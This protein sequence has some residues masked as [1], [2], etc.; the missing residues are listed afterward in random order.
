MISIKKLVSGTR[1]RMEDVNMN[2]DLTYICHNRIIV[3]SYPSSG[4]ESSYRNHYTEVSQNGNLFVHDYNLTLLYLG[5]KIFE[6]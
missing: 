4:F 3:M 6:Y 5:C 2:I 1:R